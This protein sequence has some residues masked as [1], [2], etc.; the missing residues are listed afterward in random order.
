MK[1]TAPAALCDM[2][3]RTAASGRP[4]LRRPSLR[5][6]TAAG[7][8]AACGSYG[9]SGG[10]GCQSVRAWAAAPAVAAERSEGRS[11]CFPPCLPAPQFACFDG[12]PAE[13][14]R[15]VSGRIFFPPVAETACKPGAEQ[16]RRCPMLHAC[17]PW[18]PAA[19]PFR[20]AP[21]ALPARCRALP[22]GSRAHRGPPQPHKRA[23]RAGAGARAGGAGARSRQH[24]LPPGLM[25]PRL[26]PQQR[27][28]TRPWS[29][30]GTRNAPASAVQFAFPP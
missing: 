27:R 25:G 14:R 2:P 21:H 8:S 9:S 24:A 18:L 15:A 1:R 28:R 23:G 11:Q 4:A 12:L 13:L 26:L 19:D 3:G 17:G 20:R 22:R 6:P 5:P 30:Q 16:G 7:N 10:M 29:E